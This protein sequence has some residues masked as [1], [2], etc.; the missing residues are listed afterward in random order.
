MDNLQ[1]S[2]SIVKH[3]PFVSR[4]ECLET[5]K[6]DRNCLTLGSFTLVKSRSCGTY[7]FVPGSASI[8]MSD[9]IPQ[10]D[11]FK[12]LRGGWGHTIRGTK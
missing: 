2:T 11:Y 3:G 10:A 1:I 4:T 6:R 8:L 7:D 5:A 12:T 9:D